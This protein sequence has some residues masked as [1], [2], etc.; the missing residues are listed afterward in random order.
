[1]VAK[2]SKATHRDP[3]HAIADPTRR[4]M[5]QLLAEETLTPNALAKAIPE[6]S[7]QAVSKHLQILVDCGLLALEV[8]GRNHLYSVKP[9]PMAEVYQWLEKL[10]ELWESRFEQLDTVLTE[11][12]KD[13]K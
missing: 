11:L 4:R 13:I 7:R 2:V 9:E 10:K 12:K 1:M 5:L 8:Q 3:F 6:Y